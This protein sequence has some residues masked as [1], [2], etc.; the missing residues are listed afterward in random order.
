MREFE[1]ALHSRERFG[2]AERLALQA[3]ALWDR[4]AGRINEAAAARRD[5]AQ[6]ALHFYVPT[7]MVKVWLPLSEVPD[8]LPSRP[9]RPLRVLDVGSGWGAAA[10][11]AALFL[12]RSGFGGEVALTLAESD[13]ARVRLSDAAFA[14]FRQASRLRF[15]VTR[16][17]WTAPDVRD[18]EGGDRFDLVLGL[19][20]AARHLAPQ[21]REAGCER[22]ARGLLGLVGKR[23]AV[24]LLEPAVKANSRALSRVGC[25]LRSD[26]LVHAPCPAGRICPELERSGFCFHSIDVP[27]TPLTQSVAARCG[28]ERHEANFSYLTVV[29]GREDVPFDADLPARVLS[30]PKRVG[31]GFHY[32]C[33]SAEGLTVGHARR[34]LPDGQTRGGRLKHGTLVRLEA[35]TKEGTRGG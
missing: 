20:V 9:R 4:S 19:D 25:A 22:L 23:G 17:G 8:V 1:E 24:V 26:G 31:G 28:L 27:L 2:S 13:A 33:C 6:A 16:V 15:S 21:E 5:L 10:L 35:G 11:G 30:F 12:E 3:R 18:I 7:D 34:L 32:H 29:S 14:A